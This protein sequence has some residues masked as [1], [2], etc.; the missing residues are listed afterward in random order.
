MGLIQVCEGILSFQAM[1][2]IQVCEGILS[3]QAMGLIQ[4]CEGIL[5]FQAMGLIQVWEMES[6]SF[7]A[8]TLSLAHEASGLPSKG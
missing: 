5:S 4:V 2:L 6:F 1:G 7:K 3:F 8:L